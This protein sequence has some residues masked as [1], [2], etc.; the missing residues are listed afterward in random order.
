MILFFSLY[1][2][3]WTFWVFLRL[4]CERLSAL[5]QSLQ[6]LD[7]RGKVTWR[8]GWLYWWTGLPFLIA[9]WR[10]HLR[11]QE[12]TGTTLG[13]VDDA[14]RS[15]TNKSVK[16]D[17]VFSSK[18]WKQFYI[19]GTGSIQQDMY[20]SQRERER[21]TH[22]PYLASDCSSPD[23]IVGLSRL[24]DGISDWG[25]AE[26]LR[27]TTDHADPRCSSFWA[28]LLWKDKELDLHGPMG[29]A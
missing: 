25:E 28:P 4:G 19:A 8:G 2:L 7:S 1:L 20:A 10:P 5:I 15:Q 23:P 22:P 29:A 14:F 3:V 27:L 16:C 13:V 18:C 11:R 12:A 24:G 9:V 26:V 6:G 21:G 17:L